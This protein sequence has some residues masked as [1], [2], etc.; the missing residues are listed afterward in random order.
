M[1]EPSAQKLIDL[2]NES[3]EEENDKV[4]SKYSIIIAS[5]KRARQLVDEKDSRVLG[6]ANALTIAVKEM[7]DKI[8]KI[9]KEN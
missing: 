1:F 5:A 2:V 9:V 4:K 6:G 8:V 7:K 3:I